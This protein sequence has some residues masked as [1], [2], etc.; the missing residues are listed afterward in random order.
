MAN[1]LIDT[2][3]YTLR[4]L[5]VVERTGV[6]VSVDTGLMANSI[7]LIGG[8]TGFD[9]GGDEV[10]NFSSKLT[11]RVRDYLQGYITKTYAADFPHTLNL[12]LIQAL[13]SPLPNSLTC[14]HSLG[15]SR[16]SASHKGLSKRSN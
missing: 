4:E 6:G 12:L 14:G 16:S 2:C 3:T 13:D 10:E 5:D 9:V 11:F 8:N 1:D 15:Y 7:E